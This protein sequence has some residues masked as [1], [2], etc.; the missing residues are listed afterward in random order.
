MHKCESRNWGVL[1]INPF[2]GGVKNHWFSASIKSVY[3]IEVKEIERLN[4]TTNTWVNFPIDPNYGYFGTNKANDPKY[5]LMWSLSLLKLINAG[6]SL[7]SIENEATWKPQ[8]EAEFA[9][10]GV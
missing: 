3:D 8:I 4:L 7:D 5:S 9:K 2:G 10:Y 1:F 6:V